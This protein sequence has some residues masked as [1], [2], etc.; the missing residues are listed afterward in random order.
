MGSFAK[1]SLMGVRV[2]RSR[3]FSADR[4][5]VL[6]CVLCFGIFTQGI[7]EIWR[8]GILCEIC[9]VQMWALVTLPARS[10]SIGSDRLG[11]I[12]FL[13][14]E[15]NIYLVFLLTFLLYNNARGGHQLVLINYQVLGEESAQ[16]KFRFYG[17]LEPHIMPWKVT[18]CFGFVFIC[19]GSGQ[20]RCVFG[21]AKAKKVHSECWLVKEAP[22]GSHRMYYINGCRGRLQHKCIFSMI[23]PR[24]PPFCVCIQNLLGRL[25]A[26]VCVC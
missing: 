8:P 15:S 5:L 22:D 24:T 21:Q 7:W 6:V 19:C 18:E 10:I 11:Q 12:T 14:M 2:W 20:L 13:A 3:N 26:C 16:E 4:L 25:C 17:V 1:D 9:Y 23:Y